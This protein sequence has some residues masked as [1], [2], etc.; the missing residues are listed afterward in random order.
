[1]QISFNAF[2]KATHHKHVHFRAENFKFKKIWERDMPK[3]YFN[4]MGKGLIS[5]PMYTMSVPNEILKISDTE[6]RLGTECAVTTVTILE[7]VQN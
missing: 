4:R 3:F 1:M 6:Y 5:C 2:K 7:E